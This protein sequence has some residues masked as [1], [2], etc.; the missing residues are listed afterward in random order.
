ML[1]FSIKVIEQSVVLGWK[2]F[3]LIDNSG[4]A[5][6][7]GPITGGQINRGNKTW[8]FGTVSVPKFQATWLNM[9]MKYECL[10]FY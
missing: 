5:V 1:L 2:A 6:G 10:A 7:F 4:E 3:Y 9:N 8:E